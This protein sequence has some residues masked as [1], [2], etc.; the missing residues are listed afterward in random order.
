MADDLQLALLLGFTGCENS[1]ID[2][3]IIL[4][5]DLSVVTSANLYAS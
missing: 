3:A 4:P 1:A 5:I 2:A